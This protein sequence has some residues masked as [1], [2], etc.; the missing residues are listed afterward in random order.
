MREAMTHFEIFIEDQSG[1]T[2]LDILVP[3]IIESFNATA[4]FR[5]HQYKGIGRIPKK[6]KPDGNAEKRIF[7]QQL[8]RILQGLGKTFLRYPQDYHAAAVVVCDLDNKDFHDF[9]KDIHKILNSCD[10]KPDV[11][12]CL[13]I[14]EG[15][16]WLLGDIEAIVKGYPNAKEH[17]L[18]K[19]VNDDICGT[20]ELLADA[21]HK[22][23]SEE[24]MKQGW[25]E[26][27]KGKKEWAKTICPHMDVNNN[28]SP[29]FNYFRGMLIAKFPV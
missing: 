27:G 28:A 6:L 9:R 22:G 2:M 16:A 21:I 20:W 15:E 26:I 3:K 10:P 18:K 19:Y 17:I 13:A 25:Q 8:P 24:L 29:S 14:E 1:K 23:G 5:V 4:T 12:F 11:I 7:L